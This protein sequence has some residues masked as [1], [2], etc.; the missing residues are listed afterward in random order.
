MNEVA[1]WAFFEQIIFYFLAPKCQA[2]IVHNGHVS[3]IK[4]WYFIGIF[5]FS[6]PLL[7]FHILR[8][9]SLPWRVGLIAAA[10]TSSRREAP[11]PEPN[12][13]LVILTLLVV[14]AQVESIGLSKVITQ[15]GLDE[16]VEQCL[17]CV[18]EER[19]YG[20]FPDAHKQGRIYCGLGWT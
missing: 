1:I 5:L 14:F 12:T 20:A 17:C 7:H 9:V 10:A 13:G 8:L 18:R 15:S 11:W 3:W 4:Y 16:L 19:I 6:L 2:A